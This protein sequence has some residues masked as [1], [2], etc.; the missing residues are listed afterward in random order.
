MRGWR[1]AVLVLS[2]ITALS[3]NCLWAQPY[4]VEGNDWVFN[5]SGT[6]RVP[7]LGF[8]QNVNLN[9]VPVTVDQNENDFGDGYDDF[10]VPFALPPF[11]PPTNLDGGFFTIS[12][13]P[14][15]EAQKFLPG[16]IEF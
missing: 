2:A 9:N 8:S 7:A 6:V 12:S 11:I 14:G 3:A 1:K 13:Q 16:P 10:T 15:V 4:S 5:L